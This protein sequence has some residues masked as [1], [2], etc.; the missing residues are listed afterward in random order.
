MVC[1]RSALL[2]PAQVREGVRGLGWLGGSHKGRCMG[3]A[4]SVAR[5]GTPG[6]DATIS[7]PRLFG[8]LLRLSSSRRHHVH[9]EDGEDR[10]EKLAEM[11]W[12]LLES[13]PAAEEG[14]EPGGQAQ[15][16]EQPP[17]E[18]P[19]RQQERQQE[20][21]QGHAAPQQRQRGKAARSRG[22]PRAQQ[23]DH[24]EEGSAAVQPAKHSGAQEEQE[25]AP[26]SKRQ[27]RRPALGAAGE[28]AVALA[29]QTLVGAERAALAGRA[30][31]HRKRVLPTAQQEEQL[32]EAAEAAAEAGEEQL[33]AT[34]EPLQA[35]EPAA[36]GMQADE[37]DAQQA[38]GPAKGRGPKTQRQGHQQEARQQMYADP[39]AAEEVQEAAAPRGAVQQQAEPSDGRRF[40]KQAAADEAAAPL[41]ELGVA[42]SELVL[43]SQPEPHM[44][45]PQQQQPASLAA[46]AAGA[47][48]TV[49]S[50]P[51][52][53][54]AAAAQTAALPQTGRQRVRASAAGAAP[55]RPSS[56]QRRQQLQRAQQE[57]AAAPAAPA[58]AAVEEEASPASCYW[59]DR[60][61]EYLVVLNRKAREQRAEYEVRDGVAG[62][63][64]SR[65]LYRGCHVPMCFCPLFPMLRADCHTPGPPLCDHC[66]HAHPCVIRVCLLFQP[67]REASR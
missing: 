67:R 41:A 1:R 50:L 46:G 61:A 11:R 23:E 56:R 6:A 7:L 29:E 33:E 42:A 27:R 22:R 2:Q 30:L 51:L 13:G 5:P 40:G 20:Q 21:V 47:F 38:G 48:G 19:R 62:P 10:K 25:G 53:E 63:P 65:S 17:A 12:R 43:P 39:G 8:I 49:P 52:A 44:Q 9:Y 66:L 18:P 4:C 28:A 3:W 34:L 24:P 16:G 45:Q 35:G 54:Q 36:P 58:A 64:P 14:A 59:F 57:T 37:V 26:P 32:Q 31:R 55:P 60:P 15:P